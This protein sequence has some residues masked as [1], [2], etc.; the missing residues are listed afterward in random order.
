MFCSISFPSFHCALLFANILKILF[1]TVSSM[2]NLGAGSSSINDFI[3]SALLDSN[4]MTTFPLDVSVELGGAIFTLDEVQL[5]G[6]DTL[7]EFTVE[8]IGPHTLQSRISLK[9]LSYEVRVAIDL[10]T[11]MT[12]SSSRS[13]E[14]INFGGQLVSID[15]SLALLLAVDLD[16]IGQTLLGSWLYASNILP[17]FLSSL[18][19]ELNVTDIDLSIEKLLY[20]GVTGFS[21][22]SIE[23][24]V[25]DFTEQIFGP[26]KSTIDRSLPSLFAIAM[27][28]AV[29]SFLKDFLSNSCP[30][31]PALERSK[32]IDFRDLFASPSNARISGD[33]VVKNSFQY[34]DLAP[35]I[36][37]VIETELLRID[38]GTNMP[39]I[40]EMLIAPLTNAQ[41]NRTGTLLVPGDLFNVESSIRKL[42]FENIEVR[43]YDA[44]VENLDS[45]GP[46]TLLQP[47]AAYLLKNDV[48]IGTKSKPLRLAARLV[49]SLTGSDVMMYNDLDISLELAYAEAWLALLTMISTSSFMEF[50]M[51]DITSISCW[52]ASISMPTVLNPHTLQIADLGMS[53]SEA[54]VTIKCRECTSPGIEELAANLSSSEASKTLIDL[55]NLLDNF[56]STFLEG[57]FIQGQ[58]DDLIYASQAKCPRSDKSESSFGQSTDQDYERDYFSPESGESIIVIVS[59]GISIIVLFAASRGSHIFRAKKWRSK[60]SN[61]QAEMLYDE[62]MQAKMREHLVNEETQP[63]L[64]SKSIPIYARLLVPLVVIVNIGFFLSGHL[65]LG[66]S[67][68]LD[69]E[70]AGEMITIDNFFN[71]SMAQSINQVCFCL[72]AF[73]SSF[74]FSDFFSSLASQYF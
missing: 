59:A 71:F 33:E 69:V 16:D 74:L 20:T 44:R 32:F 6:L 45:V 17:C 68:I 8:A 43:L 67:V 18:H 38:P 15:A 23:N 22:I 62:D 66:A 37:E 11:E 65:S 29:N 54:N 34:G 39:M 36:K 27:K 55:L 9:N 24:E 19:T 1:Y 46:L 7:R 4:G 47:A 72:Y 26:Y 63:L 61:D 5:S 42:G 58:L 53:I 2:I 3:N 31:P 41:S 49:F 73:V 48:I 30:E 64:L 10:P 70:F 28:G 12:S 40:N 51:K 13:V 60:L 52:L 50:P 14:N 35:K 25:A 56:T 57:E 21:S